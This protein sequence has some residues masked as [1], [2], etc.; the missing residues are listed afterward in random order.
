MQTG[1]AYAFAF[2]TIVALSVGQILFKKTAMAI[3]GAPLASALVNSK[4]ITFFIAA[5]IIYMAAT[6]CW[7]LALRQLELSKAYMLMAMCFII[8]PVASHFLLGEA[9]PGKFVVGAVLIALGVVIAY[10]N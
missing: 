7:I 1:S 4:A 5:L 2:A 10:S 3:A 8:V 9:L 6:V